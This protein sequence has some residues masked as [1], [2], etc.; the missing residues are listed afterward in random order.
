MARESGDLW[1]ALMRSGEAVATEE[2]YEHGYKRELR[3]DL[4]QYVAFRISGEMH[5]LQIAD[6]AEIAK[7]FDTT[8]VPR[9]ATF[10]L[11][12]GNVRGIVLPV[13]D[14]PRRLQLRP[15]QESRAT[16]VLIVRHEGELYG[17]VVDEVRGVVSLAPEELEEA[18]GAIA[19]TRGE[20]IEALA[21]QDGEIMVILDLATVLRTADF[22]GATVQ[23]GRRQA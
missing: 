10:V 21:R 6:I 15:V 1:Q 23:K 13:I 19:G 5:A 4:N 2:D 16:R 3:G 12:I 22:L 9:T 14:L 7:P 18:P 8:P 17:L 11:G 20:F